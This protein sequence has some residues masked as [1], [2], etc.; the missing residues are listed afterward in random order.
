MEKEKRGSESSA[1]KQQTPDG[2]RRGG[3]N[4]KSPKTPKQLN[5]EAWQDEGSDNGGQS[6]PMTNEEEG[7][8]VEILTALN[9]P[10]GEEEAWELFIQNF[11]DKTGIDVESR[12][13]TMERLLAIFRGKSE[14]LVNEAISL[15]LDM[16]QQDLDETLAYKR[17]EDQVQEYKEAEEMIKEVLSELETT[18]PVEGTVL[19]LRNVLSTT[20][21]RADCEKVQLL[22][23]S[24]NKLGDFP[25]FTTLKEQA[26]SIF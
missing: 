19:K 21:R 5:L 12:V 10:R 22:V 7:L 8:E 17:L 23:R 16:K 26:G 15:L 3:S 13:A 9:D 6:A 24:I 11:R 20:S 18:D 1:K 4:H 14:N 25:I 2:K